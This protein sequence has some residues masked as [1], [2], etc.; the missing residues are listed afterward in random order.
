MFR[1]PVNILSFLDH[2]PAN[3]RHGPWHPAAS[4]ILITFG[5][6][7][8]VS[9]K[10]AE[11][12][13]QLEVSPQVFQIQ[14]PSSGESVRIFSSVYMFMVVG[15]LVSSVGAWPLFS[16]TVTSWNLLAFRLLTS[17][18]ASA[19]KSPMLAA[20]SL[21]LRFPALVG[22]CITVSVWWV[23]LVPTI[24]YL[25]KE[26]ARRRGFLTFNFSPMLL[27]LHFLNLPI[28]LLDF[29]SSSTQLKFFDLW[30]AFFVMF[31]YILFYLNVLDPAGLQ[32]YPVFTPR[33]PLVLAT[34]PLILALYVLCHRQANVLLLSYGQN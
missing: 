21:A 27:N 18:L 4:L 1:V 2:V 28:A 10:D 9:A 15:A 5:L 13:Y 3:L 12:S 33:T 24:Y 14:E 16:Y 8:L 6:W 20:I 32:F 34:Y 22:A 31:I 23:V 25:L 19:T 26:P 7:L 17:G 30:T 29:F 11:R